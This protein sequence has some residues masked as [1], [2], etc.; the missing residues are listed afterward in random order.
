ML[1]CIFANLFCIWL[2]KDS[3]IIIICFCIQ[4]VV[5]AE[6][7]EEVLAAKICSWKREECFNSFVDIWP[8]TKTWQV[9]LKGKLQHRI[10]D[11]IHGLFILPH[12]ERIFYLSAW[13]CTSHIGHL[14]NA[15]TFHPT[16]YFKNH[17]FLKIVFIYI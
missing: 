11:H 6:A 4:S 3:W 16:V 7:Y 8:S 15:D 12:L 1:F 9:F 14:E 10:W 2:N 17:I 13:S 5:L